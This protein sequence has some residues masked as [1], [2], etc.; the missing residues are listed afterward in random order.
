M[1][2]PATSGVAQGS[3]LIPALYKWLGYRTGRGTKQAPRWYE[4]GRSCY[5][6]EDKEALERDLNKLEGWVISSHM[7]FNKERC[8]ILHLDIRNLDCTG[9][10]TSS[11]HSVVM[12][13]LLYYW[14]HRYADKHTWRDIFNSCVCMFILF[15]FIWALKTFFRLTEQKEN[16]QHFIRVHS[17]ELF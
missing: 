15:Y 11:R 12:G 3:I 17:V 9:L 5:S 10:S 1:G 13:L 2:W 14:G 16:M 7:K 8:Q 6:L 4:T